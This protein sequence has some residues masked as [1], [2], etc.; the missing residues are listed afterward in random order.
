MYKL[1]LNTS[2]NQRNKWCRLSEVF[3]S[4]LCC[5]KLFV[6]RLLCRKV[7]FVYSATLSLSL[8]L[9]S[10]YCRKAVQ[11]LVYARLQSSP[12]IGN[13]IYCWRNYSSL[14][15]YCW[16][17]KLIF[18]ESSQLLLFPV[19]KLFYTSKMDDYDFEE[20]PI[21]YNKRDFDVFLEEIKQKEH[22]DQ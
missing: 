18:F 16:K 21:R 1:S 4:S 10:L 17:F 9:K 2:K 15:L 20:N 7:K 3:K 11:S 8:K 19:L 12:T 13:P 5:R 6:A 14:R 22:F